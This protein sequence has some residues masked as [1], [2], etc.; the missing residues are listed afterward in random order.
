MTA[1]FG[2]LLILALVVQSIRL[3]D[4]RARLRSRMSGATYF[5]AFLDGAREVRRG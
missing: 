4:A 3:A 5:A 2:G 1:C